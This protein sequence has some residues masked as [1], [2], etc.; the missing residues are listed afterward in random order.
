MMI[1][2]GIR[3]TIRGS[4]LIAI[5]MLVSGPTGTS[6]IGSVVCMY[7]STRKSTAR[8][9]C[10][11]DRGGGIGSSSPCIAPFA[12]IAAR[13]SGSRRAPSASPG[14]R[15]P[16]CRGSRRSIT[17]S[18][19]SVQY[20]TGL[21]PFTVVA[22]TSSRSGWSAASISA[23]AS[24]VPVSTSRISFFGT[25]T[26]ARLAQRSSDPSRRSVVG[27]GSDRRGRHRPPPPAPVRRPPARAPTD[28]SV[29]PSAASWTAL[30]WS[31]RSSSSGMWQLIMWPG[32][33]SI[34]RRLGDLAQARGSPGGSGC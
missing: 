13:G 14:P 1:V 3:S 31:R 22:A 29:T 17:R 23:T 6:E 32:S 11:A 4:S 9:A 28:V 16:G 25:W 18:V 19:L 26:P 2:S 24:S 5:A 20:S 15:R 33:T 21:L 12:A 10:F 30:R 8:R 34:E 27:P 7:V